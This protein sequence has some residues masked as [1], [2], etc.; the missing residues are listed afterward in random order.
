MAKTS[1]Q[2]QSPRSVL[3]PN[4]VAELLMVSPITVRQWA[5]KGLID[6]HVTAGGHRRFTLEAVRRFARERGLELPALPQAGRKVLIVDDDAQLNQF[7]VAL[8]STEVEGVTVLSAAD[9][10]EAGRLVAT[11]RPEVVL[12]D[13]MMPGID[14]VDVCRRI[15]ASPETA[16]IRVVGMTGFH[17]QEVAGRMLGAGAEALLKKPFSNAEVLAAC[18]FDDR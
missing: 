13:V 6:A 17:T 12:L 8:F 15:K 4:E 9:G 16:H 10:F 1:D 14:G 2:R 11:H 5:Q 18:G 3:S 7:L